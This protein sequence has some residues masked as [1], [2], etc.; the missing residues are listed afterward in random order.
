MYI[1]TRS[2]TRRKLNAFMHSLRNVYARVCVCGETILLVRVIRSDK[3]MKEKNEKES[4]S[5]IR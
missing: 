1:Y 4:L 5:S 3:G 2:A